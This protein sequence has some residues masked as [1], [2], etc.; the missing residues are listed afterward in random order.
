MLRNIL[1]HKLS[2]YVIIKLLEKS[3]AIKGSTV[4]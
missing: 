4:A 2:K 3:Q 1:G